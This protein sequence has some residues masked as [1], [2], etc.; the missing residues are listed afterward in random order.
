MKIHK[1]AELF[2][3]LFNYRGLQMLILTQKGAKI[4]IKLILN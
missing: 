4:L 3:N 1:N 2:Y